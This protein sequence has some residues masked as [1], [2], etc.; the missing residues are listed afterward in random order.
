[1]ANYLGVAT[2]EKKVTIPAAM[3]QSGVVLNFGEATVPAGGG[4]RGGQGFAA[5]INGPV[6]DA[7]V[8]YVNDQRVGAAWCFPYQVDLTGALKEGENTI[9]IDVGN[10]AVN[11]LAKAGWPNYNQRAV[12][13]AFPPGNRFSPP[14][15]GVYAQPL[16]SGLTGPIKLEAAPRQGRAGRRFNPRA[17]AAWLCAWAAWRNLPSRV[18]G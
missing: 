10:T 4:G 15:A 6:E 9:R 5:P 2:Y 1:M 17:A 7:A 11:Y 12:D 14:N 18:P 16:P 13:A 8:V 3:A